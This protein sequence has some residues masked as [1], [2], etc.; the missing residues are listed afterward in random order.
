VRDALAALDVTTFYGRIK[1]A[2]DGSNQTKPMVTTQI[3]NGVLYTVFPSDVANGT[4][5]YPGQA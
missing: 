1:F 2:T 3:Q 4:L 5:Q